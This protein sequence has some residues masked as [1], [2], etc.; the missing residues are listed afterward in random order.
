MG[1][2]TSITSHRNRAPV[3]TRSLLTPGEVALA[4]KIHPKS[5]TRWAKQGRLSSIRT[6]GGH[7]RYFED[8]VR[9]LLNEVQR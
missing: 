5:V 6:P 1:S 2:V 7:R 8:E 4:F 3:T 9:G